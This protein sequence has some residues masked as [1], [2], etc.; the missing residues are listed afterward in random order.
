MR[1]SRKQETFLQGAKLF[2][3]EASLFENLKKGPRRQNTGMHCYVSLPSIWMAKNFVATSLSYFYES[4][5]SQ[6]CEDFTGGVGHRGI[7]T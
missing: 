3:A 5:A 2:F 4:G 6:S 1:R 7:S